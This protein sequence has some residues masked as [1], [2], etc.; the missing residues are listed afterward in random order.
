MRSSSR[1]PGFQL[2]TERTMRLVL[3][4]LIFTIAARVPVDTDLGW[5]LRTGAYTLENGVPRTDPFSF[6]QAGAPWVNH[7]WG[8]QVLMFGVYRIGGDLGLTVYMAGLAALG[9]FC[10]E[11][12]AAVLGAKNG[13][14]RA[15]AVVL[16]AAAAA[17]FWSPR[18]QMLSFAFSA[19][20]FWVLAGWRTRAFD[21]L[22]VFPPLMAVWGNLHAGFSIGFLFMAATWAGAVLE[23]LPGRR[24]PE[25]DAP[26]E[27]W[28]R[29]VKLSAV[30]GVSA[31]ALM[32]NPYGPA[33]LAVPFQTV[34]IGALRDFIQEWNSPNFHDRSTW[35]FIVLLLGVLGTVG[36]SGKMLRITDYLLVAGTAFM[37][38]LAGRNIAVFAVAATPV[39]AVFAEAALA[40]RGWLFQP[41]RRVSPLQARANALLL[42][43]VLVGSAAKTLLVLEP[44]TVAQAAE[45]VLP[46]R[47][48][49]AYRDLD[50]PPN[51]FNSYNWGGYLIWALPDVPVFVDGRTDLYGDAFL[52][53]AYLQTAFGAPGWQATLDSY[54]VNTVFVES[55][56]GLGRAV[57]EAPGWNIAYDDGFAVIALREP[58]IAPVVSEDAS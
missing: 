7:S 39:F 6:T 38:L 33:M 41:A 3:F 43:I 8:A 55:A 11:R 17:V 44:R 28:A 49:Q 51:L 35:P 31:L 10:V 23:C 25:T 18:P 54:G 27:T 12:S 20:A 36:A 57:R 5:H 30:I 32:I 22:W 48:V 14:V 13:Y 19:A 9:M 45:G 53:G 58:P 56:S 37:G 2:T 47:A 1:P 26:A 46:V 15:F 24:T 29:V 34:S 21:R 52:T 4:A 42:L 16:G 50:A 40:R